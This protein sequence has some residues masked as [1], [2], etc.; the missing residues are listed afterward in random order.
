M[1]ANALSVELEAVCKT[2]LAKLIKRRD[3]GEKNFLFLNI[4][5]D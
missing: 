4:T 5:L 3:L 1:L 2:E